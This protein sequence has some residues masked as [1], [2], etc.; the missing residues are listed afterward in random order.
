MRHATSGASA[1]GR[2]AGRVRPLRPR[3]AGE[4]AA[5]VR[6]AF[7]AQPVATDPP[8]SALGETADTVRAQLASGG[9]FGI[10]AADRLV[11]V[12]L[13][14][15]IDGGMRRGRLAVVPGWRGQGVAGALV[16]AVEAEARSRGLLRL[17]LGVRVGLAGNRRLFAAL[18]FRETA[19]RC[20]PGHAEPT[21]ADMEK[22]LTA[23]AAPVIGHNGGPPLED[24]EEPPDPGA[25]WRRYCWRRAHRRAWKTPPREIALRRLERAEALGMTYREY[26]LEIMERGRH[27]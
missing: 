8:P 3:D 26:A 6:A 7:A 2:W 24:A 21:S 22:A 19:L 17:Q 18:G 25:S 27:P 20:H 13:W 23:A 15:P 16:G 1:A 10:E 4:A 12:V 14:A 11:G 5:V 9:G